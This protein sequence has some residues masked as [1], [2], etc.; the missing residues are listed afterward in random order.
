MLMVDV[1]YYF[2]GWLGSKVGGKVSD[3]LVK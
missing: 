3:F 1:V 2:A